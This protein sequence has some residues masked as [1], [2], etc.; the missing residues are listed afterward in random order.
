MEQ[1]HDCDVFRMQLIRDVDII[2][3]TLVFIALFTETVDT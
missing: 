1:I 3:T 2:I